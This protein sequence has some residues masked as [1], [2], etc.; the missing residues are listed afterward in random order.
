ML[1]VLIAGATELSWAK[2]W[3]GRS[4]KDGETPGP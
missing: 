3:K 2:G 4:R 1:G